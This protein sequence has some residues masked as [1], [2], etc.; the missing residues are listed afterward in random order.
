MK[1]VNTLLITEAASSIAAWRL[2][3]LDPQKLEA[4][5]LLIKK[6]TEVFTNC[7]TQIGQAK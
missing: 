1:T 4:A 7:F 2:S 3:V 5:A 6:G